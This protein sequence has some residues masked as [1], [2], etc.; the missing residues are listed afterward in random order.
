MLVH[1]KVKCVNILF[2]WSLTCTKMGL[3]QWLFTHGIARPLKMQLKMVIWQENGCLWDA[4]TFEC[5]A[6]GGK[7]KVHKA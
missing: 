4:K 6:A 3:C 7:L 1:G 2:G 5:T